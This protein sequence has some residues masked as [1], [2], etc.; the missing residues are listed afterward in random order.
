[1]KWGKLPACHPESGVSF[2]LAIRVLPQA[3]SLRH[4]HNVTAERLK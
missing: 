3:G 4:F 1:M 2:Q